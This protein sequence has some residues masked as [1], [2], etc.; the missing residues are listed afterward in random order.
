[1]IENIIPICQNL[2]LVDLANDEGALCDFLIPFI[3]EHRR[4]YTTIL[5]LGDIATISFEHQSVCLHSPHDTIDDICIHGI[6]RFTRRKI[7]GAAWWLAHVLCYCMHDKPY[8]P[9]LKTLDYDL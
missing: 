5:A 6:K 9:D 2:Q 4:D 7:E 3:S 8:R 1:M